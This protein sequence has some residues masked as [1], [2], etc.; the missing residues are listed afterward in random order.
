MALASAGLQGAD[1]AT[2]TA[3][4]N[5]GISSAPAKLRG[6]INSPPTNRGFSPTSGR[7]AMHRKL[8]LLAVPTAL[9]ALVALSLYL[10]QDQL[11]RIPLP[12][13]V[14]ENSATNH[15]QHVDDLGSPEY[16]S[17]ST[18]SSST[19]ITTSTTSAI[20]TTPTPSR[21]FTPSN[22]PALS[23][24]PTRSTTSREP[25][26]TPSKEDAI[27]DGIIL[28]ADEITSYIEAILD[29]DA[30]DSQD[31]PRLECPT[32]NST[33]YSNLK[34]SDH[35]DTIEYYFAM[36]LRQCLDLLPTLIG[37]I[38][39]A[40]RF[41]GPERCALSIIEGHSPDGTYDVLKA[42]KR[43]V[44]DLG[45]TYFFQASRINPKEGDRI[46]KLA[47]LR[48]LAIQPLVN[49]LADRVTE[50]STVV[51]LNDVAACPEDILELVYQRR[52]LGAD[53][54]CAMDWTYVGA[55]P[56]FYDVWIARGI[57]GDSFF[58]IPKDGSWENAW[59]L[60]WNADE[61]RSRF[62]D[63]IP[64]QAFSCW[65]GAVTFAADIITKEG[66]R[67]RRSRGDKGECEQGEPTLLCKDMWFRGRGKI[68]V[69]PTVNLEYS[70][71]KGRE[72]KKV[73]GFVSDHVAK[74]D[75][76]RDQFEWALTPPDK[77]KCIAGWQNQWWQEWNKTLSKRQRGR[78]VTITL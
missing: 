53:M 26:E 25:T 33:R 20:S 27:K 48:N 68:A 32:L 21:I 9:F 65:N 72:I 17:T 4:K 2:N 43:N 36:D 75:G 74:Q 10:S 64:F 66:L 54:T 40:M 14:D 50:T 78:D 61:T 7:P 76:V 73:K 46:G 24:T 11:R 57:N 44:Q 67:F 28:K 8:W 58:D 6:F 18:S 71:D 35:G 55:D 51:F 45:A 47:E 63:N 3:I 16:Y 1:P 19:T 62:Y 70:V 5:G 69:V 12:S 39:E 15:T 77:I 60:F 59:N 30:R 23:T 34:L 41:L 56:T 22:T 37:S 52:G 49:H 13:F 38:V 42:L 29:Q 31:F